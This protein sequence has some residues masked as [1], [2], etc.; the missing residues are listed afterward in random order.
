MGSLF[1]TLKRCLPAADQAILCLKPL[2]VDFG[3]PERVTGIHSVASPT[4]GGTIGQ[5]QISAIDY[6]PNGGSSVPGTDTGPPD[7]RRAVPDIPTDQRDGVDV[8]LCFIGWTA[9]PPEP[10]HTANDTAPT[11]VLPP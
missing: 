6:D 4:S 1:Y 8:V 9:V 5:Q 10:D 3:I 2:A 11:T 7:Q